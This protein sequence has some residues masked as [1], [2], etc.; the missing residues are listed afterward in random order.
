MGLQ[1]RKAELAEALLSGSTRAL[2][3]DEALIDDLLA[4]LVP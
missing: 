1:T 2:D 3:L 4:P